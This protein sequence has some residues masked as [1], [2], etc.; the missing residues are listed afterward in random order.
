MIIFKRGRCDLLSGRHIMDMA[1]C[2][3][4]DDEIL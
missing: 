4:A 3:M 2:S 1:E